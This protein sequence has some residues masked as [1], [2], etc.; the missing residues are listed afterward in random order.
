ML[1][2]SACFVR[3]LIVNTLADSEM[4][5]IIESIINQAEGMCPSAVARSMFLAD[6]TLKCDC[7]EP[8]I[9][10]ME[11]L[12]RLKESLHLSHFITMLY[13][14][15]L[16]SASRVARRRYAMVVEG[17]IPPEAEKTRGVK[18]PCSTS[19]ILWS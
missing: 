17:P 2:H 9:A 12:K 14:I 18:E 1:I 15:P 3:P 10:A 16:F 5:N 4:N 13:F 6:W 7:L 11:D 19:L 8:L